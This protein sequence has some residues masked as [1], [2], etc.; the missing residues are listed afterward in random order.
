VIREQ[1]KK[2]VAKMLAMAGT[3]LYPQANP[4]S[5]VLRVVFLL[6]FVSLIGAHFV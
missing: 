3:G 5:A 6:A 4:G 2:H 1:H